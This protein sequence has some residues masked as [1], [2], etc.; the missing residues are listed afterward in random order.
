[1]ALTIPDLE[2]ASI[3][4][5]NAMCERGGIFPPEADKFKVGIVG[6]CVAGLFTALLF[7]WL[8]Q[9]LEGK[10]AST[11]TSSRL[12]M[13]H[14]LVGASLPT[15]SLGMSMTTMTLGRCVFRTTLS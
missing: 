4:D 6:A 15:A 11:T 5:L 8:I 12:P 13:N 9:E 10:L 1:M 14:V 7:D 2:E 3:T